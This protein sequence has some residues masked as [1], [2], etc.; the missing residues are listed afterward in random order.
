MA[1]NISIPEVQT[2]DHRLGTVITYHG[3]AS[4]LVKLSKDRKVNDM[5]LNN[6]TENKRI[7]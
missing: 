6:D 3:S 4:D 1:I 5:H 2:R 7:G